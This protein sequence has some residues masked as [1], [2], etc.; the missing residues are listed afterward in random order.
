LNILLGILL[1]IYIYIH[2]YIYN[3]YIYIY[4][5]IYKYIYINLFII[6]M[7][8]SMGI[9][10]S[11]I[12]V[13]K[14]ASLSALEN[15]L[16]VFTFESAPPSEPAKAYRYIYS[17]NQSAWQAKHTTWRLA[18]SEVSSLLCEKTGFRCISN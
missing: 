11:A 4:S 9:D 3:I 1:G 18:G 16:E 2:I 5:S 8:L 13:D 14:A 6:Y 12:T 15:E 7:C 17:I 10:T